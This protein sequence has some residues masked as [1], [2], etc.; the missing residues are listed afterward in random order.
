MQEA[1]ERDVW[2]NTSF[3]PIGSC[4]RKVRYRVRTRAKNALKVMLKHPDVW[5]GLEEYHCSH[6]Q[7]YHLG[8]KHNNIK[9]WT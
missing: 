2:Y 9:E 6:C 5:F 8:H 3:I 7:G 4:L 1:F